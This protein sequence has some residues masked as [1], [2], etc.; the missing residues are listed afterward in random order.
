VSSAGATWVG[1]F[2]GGASRRMGGRPKG[3]LMAPDG[4]S[5]LVARAVRIVRE[6]LLVPVFVGGA[7]WLD[8]RA[9]GVDVIDDDP[10][11]IGPLG[12]LHALLGATDATHA[13]ALACDMP[14]VTTDLLRRL[15]D[16]PS[17]AAIVAPRANPT[18]PW[19][20]MFGRYHC[21]T[22]RPVAEQLI[23]RG[24]DSIQA[25]FR[26]VST[27]DL[28]MAAHERALLRDWDSPGDVRGA[29]P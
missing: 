17:G 18:E 19:E 12:G 27:D 20:A 3:L 6:G 13:I 9:W 11:G 15:A 28:P 26:E 24:V 10:P 2:V 14:Y 5:S 4:H 21:A 25:L 29:K 7:P 23:A 22:V 1:I 16:H 8:A